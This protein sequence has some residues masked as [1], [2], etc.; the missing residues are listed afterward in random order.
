MGQDQLWNSC[1]IVG[2]RQQHEQEAALWES[3]VRRSMLPRQ[4][5]HL[6]WIRN[7]SAARIR[8]HRWL[9]LDNHHQE[10]DPG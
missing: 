9:G 8:L 6:H 1:D 2:Q 3:V 10:E 7:P 5:R 4:R